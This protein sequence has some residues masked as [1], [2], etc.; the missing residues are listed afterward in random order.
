MKGA[1]SSYTNNI[2]GG[3]V[4]VLFLL[5]LLA[6]YLL[7]TAGL[8]S[9]A[10]ISFV[11]VLILAIIVLLRYP[12]AA[13]W[14]LTFINYFVMWQLFPR[15]S[16]I[17]TSLYNEMFEIIL[18]MLAI[19]NTKD[20][21]F[22]RCNNIMFFALTVWCTFC[23]LEVLNNTCGIGINIS[24]WFTGVRLMAFQLLYAFIVFSL[25]ISKPSILIKYLYVWGALSLFAVFWIWKQKYVGLTTS[26]TA[27]LY[28][29]HGRQHLLQAGT[30]IRYWSIYSDA[31]TCGIGMASTATA[32]I[33]FS[34]ASKTT[35]HKIYFLIVGIANAWG[36][37][38]TGTRTAIICFIAGL[39]AYIFLSKSFK[40]AIPFTIVFALA[41]FLLAFTKIG[42]SN[43]Q[44]RRMRS[45]F[46]R[47][48]ASTNV[49]TI[50]Q[51][52]MK[53]YMKEA[54]WGVGIGMMSN[55]LPA[56]NKY[57]VLLSIPPDSEYVFIWIRT[58]KIGISIFIITMLLMLGGACWIILFK[59]K[60][61]TLRGIG[62][63]FCCAFVSQQ[64]GGY[65]NQVLMQFPNCLTIYG[66]LSIVYILPFIEKEWVKYENKLLAQQEDRKR[67]KLEK[68]K[69][70]RV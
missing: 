5:F 54:P 31:A 43:Q 47:K 24:V 36:I 16:G 25:Y 15:P 40:I 66:G 33:I 53:R 61:P 21:R 62:A 67:L 6:L 28:G 59:L 38:P 35:K 30:L 34:I 14:A 48:D 1:S 46:D 11:P 32:F 7:A 13:F 19:I 65:G 57:K 2:G 8:S 70:S 44:I 3:R 4:I 58:G 64:L 69:A 63:G 12:I 39:M 60:S 55:N 52:A 17:P 68:K 20:T 41:V 50:N 51:T 9:F 27:W 29:P 10:V 56:R 49:R 37:F 26:E 18:I 22:E 42:N 23:I 45:A